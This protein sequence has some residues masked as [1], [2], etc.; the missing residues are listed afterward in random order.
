MAT[1]EAEATA[2]EMAAE[3]PWALLFVAVMCAVELQW[4]YAWGLMKTGLK[5]AEAA[6]VVVVCR[7]YT[8]HGSADVVTFV[9]RQL[10]N[11]TEL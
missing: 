2:A 6:A 4:R 5:L 10:R 7:W 3:L 8:A 11:F 9:R 1:A